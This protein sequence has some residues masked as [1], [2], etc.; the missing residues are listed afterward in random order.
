MPVII[1]NDLP[2]VDILT[3][4]KIF[5]MTEQTAIHQDI[6]PL[7]IGI[8]NLMPT[9]EVTETQ[10]LRLLGNSP[11]QIEITLVHM[12]SHESKNTSI[13]HLE[14]FYQSFDEI[15]H[16]KF[17][18]FIITG[19]PVE[20][21]PFEAV[22]YWEELTEVMEWTKHN[23]F[24]T[25]HICWGAQ[26]AANYHFGLEK[27]DLDK[28]MFGVFP[29]EKTEVES[30]LLKGFDDVFHIPHSRHTFV[31]TEDI[32]KIPEL[33][34]IAYSE[35]AGPSILVSRNHRMVF[36]F[37]HSEYDPDTLKREYDRDVNKGLTIDI[38]RHYYKMDDPKKSP[39]VTWRAHG[40]LLFT[41]WLNYFVYQETP[42]DLST[43]E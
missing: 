19:A 29:H 3:Q 39:K 43:I 30:M 2:A 37:G 12:K 6:R 14:R 38:P 18:G 42:Y 9:K 25:F 22:D 24:S 26:A 10:L 36:A 17:D 40:T 13:E 16:T 4:E 21:H 15:R 23:V 41:N 1:P 11:L 34:I 33:E 8:L 35:E 32:E 27:F 20:S 5:V 28:K 31:K 7:K